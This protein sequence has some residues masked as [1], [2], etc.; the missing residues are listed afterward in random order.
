M[1]VKIYNTDPP[2]VMST[3]L[4]SLDVG[5]TVEFKHIPFNVKKQYPFGVKR[6]CMLAAGTGIT[7]MIQALHVVLGTKDDNT[8]V[9]LMYGSQSRES[10]LAY[11]ILEQWSDQCKDQLE[12]IHVLSREEGS[13]WTGER[14]HIRSEL[15]EK[16]CPPA[17]AE[18]LFFVC[19]PTAMYADICG[20]RG[21]AAVAG[22]LK[23]LGYRD[24][25]VVK[26]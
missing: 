7:P 9:T 23:K 24:D 11:E 26:F 12:V 25:Q 20:P 1:Q 17:E 6:I 5:D 4:G 10:I 13:S 19:G 15:I 22:D 18:V 21:E 3:H 16:Y 14:G 8:Q 2:G